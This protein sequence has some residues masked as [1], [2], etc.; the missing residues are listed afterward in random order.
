MSDGVIFLQNGFFMRK[1]LEAVFA[2]GRPDAGVVDAAEWQVRVQEMHHCKVYAHGARRGARDDLI[3]ETLAIVEDIQ[4]KRFGIC[5]DLVDHF[6][7]IN[8]FDDR[9]NWP[10]QL[11]LS[12]FHIIRNLGNQRRGN[13]VL[14]RISLT[15]LKDT[16]AFGTGILDQVAHPVKMPIVHDPAIV[17]RCFLCLGRFPIDPTDLGL[18]RGLERGR[19]IA[20]HIH[21]IGGDT[22]LTVV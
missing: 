21:M 19:H 11:F 20:V 5:V 14:A 7:Q 2:M 16:C 18:K 9:Q 17:G 12:D 13:E 3:S 4:G 8:I 22:G 15:P 6:I 1:G 10:E